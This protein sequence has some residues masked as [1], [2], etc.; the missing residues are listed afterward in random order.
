M[1]IYK[2]TKGNFALEKTRDKRPHENN[3][4]F[5][6]K[7]DDKYYEYAID[8]INK[9]TI[10]IR[11]VICKSKA[12]QKCYARLTLTIA[13]F[14][15]TEAKASNCKKPKYQ[16]DKTNIETDYFD[17]RSFSIQTHKCSKSCL[18]GCIIKHSCKGHVVSRDRKRRHLDEARNYSIQYYTQSTDDAVKHAD[19]KV[20]F[21][22]PNAIEMEKPLSGVYDPKVIND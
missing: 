13:G 7:I 5:H 18:K 12:H 16:W 15:K 9:K 19:T 11:C 14:L 21:G 8:N 4:R 6:I 3:L 1:Q 22:L 10:N 20:G 2:I 17:L